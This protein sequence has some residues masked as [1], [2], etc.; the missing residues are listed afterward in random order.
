MAD[1]GQ[2]LDQWLWFARIV[3]TRVL[4][5]ALVRAGSV[6]VNGR[7]VDQPAR[8]VQPG[9]VLTI[10]R[11]RDVLVLEIAACAPR[12]GPA[13]AARMLYKAV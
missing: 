8:R 12:R 9:D 7:H 1:G 10:G 2:R 11:E 5:A 6:R 13:S 4:A 3:R